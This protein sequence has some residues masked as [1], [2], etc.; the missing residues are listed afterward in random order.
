M[1]KQGQG[2]C[3]ELLFSFSSEDCGFDTAF[4]KVYVISRA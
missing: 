1:S 2:Q 3:R 4:S